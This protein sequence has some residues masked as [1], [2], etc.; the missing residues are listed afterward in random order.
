MLSKDEGTEKRDL[1]DCNSTGESEVFGPTRTSTEDL[2]GLATEV[3]VTAARNLEGMA[4]GASTKPP[5][6][7][8]SE[9]WGTQFCF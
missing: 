6:L 4:L 2:V 7:L 8:K 5:T 9:G 3:L 1:C